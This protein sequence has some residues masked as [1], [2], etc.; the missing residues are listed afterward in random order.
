MVLNAL[1]VDP[2]QQWKGPWRWYSEDMLNCCLSTQHIKSNGITLKDFQCLAM[3]QG[4]SV[5]VHYAYPEQEQQDGST[6][7]HHNDPHQ[8]YPK[9]EEEE[10][11]H[12][13]SSSSSSSLM[14]FRRAV[15]TACVEEEHPVVSAVEEEKEPVQRNNKN[16]E[17]PSSLDTN[18]DNDTEDPLSILVA[19]YDRK[20][21]LQTGS[22]HFSPIAA[23]DRSSDSVLILDTARF[24]Y[25]AH[26]VSLPLLHD[27]MTTIDPD[28]CRPRGFALLSFVP[29]PPPLSSL[30]PSSQ[31]APADAAATTTSR[32]TTT[33]SVPDALSVATTP[34]RASSS[35]RSSQSQPTSFL[36]RIKMNQN[37]NRRRYKHYLQ[38]ITKEIEGGLEDG[39]NNTLCNTEMGDVDLLDYL[40]L[41][42]SSYWS[43]PNQ[44][45]RL[46][47]RTTSTTTTTTTTTTDYQQQLVQLEDDADPIGVWEIVE[48]I[49]ALDDV[50][51]SIVVQMRTLVKGLLNSIATKGGY[52]SRKGY[53]DPS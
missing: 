25:G 39:S 20:K 50:S 17:A 21:L 22:G 31:T 6:K 44:Q 2:H 33:E 3:C 19:S 10:N 5:D 52:S 49:R 47:V 42:V 13:Q 1:S 51:K 9:E 7:D 14:A 24:K 38:S 16:D 30:P 32:T 11:D 36:F 45:R 8:H 48:P 43:L 27:A 46:T 28:S 40:W 37:E 18:D 26:W 23:Y 34:R 15:K 12:H 41:K 35:I 53:G 4:L 29:P